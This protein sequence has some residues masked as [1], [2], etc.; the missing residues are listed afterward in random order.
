MNIIVT[1]ASSGIG[2]EVVKLFSRSKDNKIIAVARSEDKLL[3]LKDECLRVNNN[4]NVFPVTIDLSEQNAP[5]ALVKKVLT[6]FDNVDILLNN[7]GALLNKPF[8]EI[9]R[10]ELTYIYEVNLFSP[11]LLT[12]A[13]L[14]VFSK[15]AHIVNISSMGGFQ[16][17]SKFPGLSAYSSSKAALACF[18]ECFAEELRQ[19]QLKVNC[20]AIGSVQT[21]MLE[22]AFP[23]YS[24]PVN[25]SQMAEY[26]CDFC[27]N[28]HKFYNGKIL[29]VAL[30]T[31]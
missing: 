2:Y 5:K 31:P 29:P 18:T 17:S 11:F 22:K 3:K 10:E 16:G 13:L 27:I 30:S 21:P 20:L 14:A 15:N 28:G 7:A 6:Y 25:S 12:Q 26:I 23:G 9:T 8:K 4:S 1:G 24:A 19:S